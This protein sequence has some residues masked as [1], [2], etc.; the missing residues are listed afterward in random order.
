MDLS[1]SMTRLPRMVLFFPVA[2]S[3]LLVLS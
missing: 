3:H 1:D 2:R